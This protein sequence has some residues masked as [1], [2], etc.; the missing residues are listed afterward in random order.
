M[1]LLTIHA[2]RSLAQ[3]FFVDIVEEL[4]NGFVLGDV[5]HFVDLVMGFDLVTQVSK[6]LEILNVDIEYVCST[7]VGYRH[8]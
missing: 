5:I 7:Q 2:C 1:L 3:R 8:V 4:L 6:E